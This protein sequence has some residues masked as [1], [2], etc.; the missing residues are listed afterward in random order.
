MDKKVSLADSENNLVTEATVDANATFRH[1]LF[2]DRLYVRDDDL[3]DM[4]FA[5][6]VHTE[7]KL[8]V[9]ATKEG[10][11]MELAQIIPLAKPSENQTPQKLNIIFILVASQLKAFGKAF[12]RTNATVGKWLQWAGKV[13]EACYFGTDVPQE[14]DHTDKFNSPISDAWRFRFEVVGYQVE[15]LGI[16]LGMLDANDVGRDDDVSK[17]LVRISSV[18]KALAA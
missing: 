16:T 10:N 4:Y 5:A 3:H 18:L 17:L 14:P 6:Q 1:I 7:S 15:S 13:I 11:Q 12:E 8:K 2:K 9:I